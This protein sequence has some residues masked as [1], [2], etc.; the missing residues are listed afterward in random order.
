M[1]TAVGNIAP[2]ASDYNEIAR[3]PLE[4]DRCALLVIDVQEK[5]LPLVFQKA[6]LVKNCQSL[7]RLAGA[8]KLP[9]LI[10]TQYAQTIRPSLDI[11]FRQAIGVG[12]HLRGC[13]TRYIC[14]HFK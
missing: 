10:T 14:R 1:V 4:A 13:R 8:L 5:L 3:T 9:A 2:L 7:I 12:N 11:E 6:Q